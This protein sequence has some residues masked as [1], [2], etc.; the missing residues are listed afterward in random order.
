[1]FKSEN[2]RMLAHQ[3]S[4]FFKLLSFNTAIKLEKL[5]DTFLEKQDAFRIPY[6]SR[7]NIMPK[8]LKFKNS[9]VNI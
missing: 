6:Y 1:M 4:K 8:D 9:S 3:L 2:R 5:I 7:T